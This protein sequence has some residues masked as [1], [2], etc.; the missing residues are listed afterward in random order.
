MHP[1]GGGGPSRP[2][3]SQGFPLICSFPPLRPSHLGSADPCAML[4][5]PMPLPHT[6]MCAHARPPLPGHTNARAHLRARPPL[7]LLRARPHGGRRCVPNA[8]RAAPPCA[9]AALAPVPPRAF[10]HYPCL[11]IHTAVWL[12]RGRC[13]RGVKCANKAGRPRRR[14]AATGRGLCCAGSQQGMGAEGAGRGWWRDGP[15]RPCG[16]R[17]RGSSMWGRRVG[18]NGAAAAVAQGA[19]GTRGNKPK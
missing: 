17:D 4:K 3:T 5:W 9:A 15:A 16:G 2:W 10:L 13:C 8:P 18:M 7:N 6:R 19:V 12:A 1:L 11:D 14:T